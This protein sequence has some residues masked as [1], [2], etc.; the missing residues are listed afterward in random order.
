MSVL[1]ASVTDLKTWKITSAS[2][3]STEVQA[4]S[5]TFDRDYVVFRNW[6][7]VVLEAYPSNSVRAVR[8]IS[9]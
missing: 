8:L 7:N 4:Y 1:N 3:S 6:E 9:C 5:V 2:Y